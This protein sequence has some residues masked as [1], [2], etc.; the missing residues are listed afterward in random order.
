M[1]KSKPLAGKVALV[2]GATRGIGKGIALQLGQAGALVYITGRT[3]KSTGH[4]SLEETADEIRQRGGKCVPV[5]V[6]HEND[7]DIAQLFQRIETEQ[8]GVLD[9][10]VNNAY[11][12]VSTIFE[13]SSL[14][15]WEQKPEVWDEINNV[16]L[17][18]HYICT[19]YAA[20]L[21]V[22][23]KQGLIV[24]I[25][26]FGGMSYIFNV[27]YGV[28]K[29]AVDRMA[30]DC[31]KELMK[32]NVIML[33]LYPGAV[34]TELV[35][36]FMEK[37]NPELSGISGKKTSMKN[38]FEKGESIEFSGKI[39]VEMAQDKNISKYASKVVIGADY[40]R[41]HGLK[42]IDGQEIMS[43]RQ[44]KAAAHYLPPSLKWIGNLIPGFLTVP[45]FIFDILYS[46]YC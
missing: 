35:T 46:K 40:G 36:E 14:K 11:K 26:S 24:N 9:I 8:N 2:T 43:F 27:A 23:R 31:G 45:Q 38:I 18:N 39:I 42:D 4:G 15:F 1:S 17:R 44:L 21:M 19:V 5:Q 3:L 6:D 22:P 16:G 10:L 28:G 13:S 7:H 20:R 25:S 32:H 29:A 30:V 33:S 37:E 34:K 12:G 41:A